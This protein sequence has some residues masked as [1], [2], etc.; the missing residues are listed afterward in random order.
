MFEQHKLVKRSRH[1]IDKIKG[2]LGERPTE[3][4]EII[5]ILNSKMKEELE[6]LKI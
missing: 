4:N 3:A 6:A 2:E 1:A 5:R